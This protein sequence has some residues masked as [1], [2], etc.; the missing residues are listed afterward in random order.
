LRA[1]GFGWRDGALALALALIVGL[2]GSHAHAEAAEA[3]PDGRFVGI[4]AD[5]LH[6]TMGAVYGAFVRETIDA[7]ERPDDVAGGRGWFVHNQQTTEAHRGALLRPWEHV[8]GLVA[9]AIEP[10][11]SAAFVFHLERWLAAFMFAFG[12][13][14]LGAE[15]FARLVTRALFLFAAGLG[16]NLYGLVELAGRPAFLRHWLDDY[17]PNLSGLGFS[18]P[19]YLLGVPHLAMEIGCVAMG[20]AGLLQV[21]RRPDG[22]G[23]WGAALLGGLGIFGLAAI[24]P[25]T[26]PVLFVVV[27]LALGRWALR[28][29]YVARAL[30]LITCLLLSGAV[31][32]GFDALALRGDSIFSALDVVHPSPPLLEQALFLGAPLLVAIALLPLVGSRLEPT[33]RLLLATWLVLGTLLAN[34]APLVAWEVEALSPLLLGWLALAVLALESWFETGARRRALGLGLL[35]LLVGLGSTRARL[36]ELETHLA[37]RDRYLWMSEAEA[38]AIDWLAAHRLPGGLSRDA[39]RPG[40]WVEPR[41][42]AALVPWLAGVRVFLGHP[43]HTPESGRKLAFSE[44]FL[45]DGLGL[46]LLKEAGVTHLVR[47]PEEGRDV[48]EGSALLRRVHTGR[49]VIDQL[50]G[51]KPGMRD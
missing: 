24:R 3:H 4:L 42:L 5:S 29:R 20:F 41:P 25:Y 37:A 17:L 27:L 21:L 48:L 9:R 10:A 33:R 8:L 13:A 19:S 47:W 34:G 46:G 23:A 50:R 28:E 40:V 26:A 43:D 49:V 51:A 2:W 1:L 35:M 32:L 16:G 31:M 45:G 39:S 12:V 38:E 14:W 30:G 44:R 11:D 6:V 18:Y 7:P 36:V 22:A 15:L